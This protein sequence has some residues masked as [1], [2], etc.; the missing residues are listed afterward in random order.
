MKAKATNPG[1]SSAQSVA[2]AGAIFQARLGYVN[3]TTLQLGP[4]K[5][6]IVA[7]GQSTDYVNVGTPLTVTTLTN[8]IDATGADSTAPPGV[9][10]VGT[11]VLYYA[12]VS[13]GSASFAPRTL[14]LSATAPSLDANSVY[15]LGV[16]GNA[17]NW[18]FVGLVV[19]FND[20]GGGGGLARFYPQGDPAVDQTIIGFANYY[21][22][23]LCP[24]FACPGYSDNNA[25][26]TYNSPAA[27]NMRPIK[28]GVGD[29]VWYPHLG[30]DA[31]NFDIHVSLTE[32]AAGSYVGIG[33][34]DV[35]VAAFTQ[36]HGCTGSAAVGA[37]LDSCI[38]YKKNPTATMSLRKAAILIDD[39]G[40]ACVVSADLG[41]SGGAADMPATYLTGRISA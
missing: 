1:L 32:G 10:V 4:Y 40:F 41:R 35:S 25:I 37:L 12:Y 22:R 19:I 36:A 24:L 15:Y 2:L 28:G 20:G 27:A 3:S 8:L 13:N 39:F 34:Q 6:E 26:T 23:E 17:L 30:E 16:A 5:G 7:V 9:P 11:P 31:V 21:N 14:K 18:R 38:N 29:T 33:D